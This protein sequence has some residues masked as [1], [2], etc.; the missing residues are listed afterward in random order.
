MRCIYK[1][2]SGVVN[3]GEDEANNV[4]IQEQLRSTKAELIDIDGQADQAKMQIA[5][6]EKEIPLL[7]SKQ[8]SGNEEVKEI[9][10]FAGGVSGDTADVIHPI[11]GDK[12]KLHRVLQLS[13]YV[14]GGL[15][16]IE[17]KPLPRRPVGGG[18]SVRRLDT[19]AT[20]SIDGDD[21]QRKWI[22]R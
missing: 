15:E 12:H 9:Q 11:T 7:E 22:F 21:V 18:T 8:E 10:V 13:W 5:H 19:E 2:Y 14:D 6:L 20:D 16:Q 17:L 1:F 3:A 4:S